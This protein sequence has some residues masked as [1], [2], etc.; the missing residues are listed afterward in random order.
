VQRSTAITEALAALAFAAVLAIVGGRML[1]PPWP[2]FAALGVLI[3]VNLARAPA[4]VIAC[5]RMT[6][7]LLLVEV[8][9]G[10]AWV[11]ASVLTVL[12]AWR[13]A[14]EGASRTRPMIPLAVALV[15]AIAWSAV[16][17]SE[18]VWRS[19]GTGWVAGVAWAL[20]WRR[21]LRPRAEQDADA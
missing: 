6:V 5:A 16:R 2:V 19:I 7:G 10:Y 21:S 17:P 18:N 15:I 4:T 14:R 13:C 3:V 12:V 9:H 1:W 8:W 20:A 11:V